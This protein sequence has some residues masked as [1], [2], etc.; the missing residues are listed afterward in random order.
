[1]IASIP[2]QQM[3]KL[4]LRKIHLPKVIQQ[5]VVQARFSQVLGQGVEVALALCKMQMKLEKNT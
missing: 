2:I 1:M 4:R 5:K 3:G